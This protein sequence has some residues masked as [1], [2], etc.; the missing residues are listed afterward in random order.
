MRDM[1][2][3]LIGLVPP[4]VESKPTVEPLRGHAQRRRRGIRSVG[5][6]GGLA[7]HRGIRGGVGIDR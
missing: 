2:G 4:P 3:D 7:P 6:T 5:A 1:T